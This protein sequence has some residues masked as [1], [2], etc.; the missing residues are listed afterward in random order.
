MTS[1]VLQYHRPLW[2]STIF[3][4]SFLPSSL[5]RDTSSVFEVD[6][7]STS[8]AIT[9][10]NPSD[11]YVFSPSVLALIDSLRCYRSR[12]GM[13]REGAAII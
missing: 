9:C 13:I 3:L 5:A 1:H 10:G 12:G 7:M 4:E 11:A 8:A 6:D 2:T